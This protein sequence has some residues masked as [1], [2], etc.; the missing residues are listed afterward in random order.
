M[1]P[2]VLVNGRGS[3]GSNQGSIVPL[4]IAGPVLEATWEESNVPISACSDGRIRGW[5]RFVFNSGGFTGLWAKCE[6]ALDSTWNGTR[7]KSR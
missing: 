1:G 3:Y 2:M 4:R 6:N 5:V 7:R